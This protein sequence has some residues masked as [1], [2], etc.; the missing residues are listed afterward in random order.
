MWRIRSLRAV[1]LC[2]EKDIPLRG[3]P[4]FSAISRWACVYI[5]FK[6]MYYV[7]IFFYNTQIF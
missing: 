3:N 7:A 6:F 4:P 5:F 2:S 1:L